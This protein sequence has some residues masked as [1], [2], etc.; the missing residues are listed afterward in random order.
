MDTDKEDHAS[1]HREDNRGAVCDLLLV[2]HGVT[3]RKKS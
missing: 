2:I 1:E 3:A